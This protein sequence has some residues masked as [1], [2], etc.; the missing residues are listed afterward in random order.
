MYILSGD[1]GGTKTRLALYERTNLKGRDSFKCRAV[2]DFDSRSKLSLEEIVSVFLERHLSHDRIEAACIGV[3]GPIL[4]GTVRATNL[5]WQ[6]EE[7]KFAG[8]LGIPRF[9][10]VNDH[11]ATAASIPLL[12]T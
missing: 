8:S 1:A 11:V 5:P 2:A 9:R 12:G 10:L 7:I 6:I 4:G 3:P